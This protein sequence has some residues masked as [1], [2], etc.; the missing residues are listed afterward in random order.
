MSSIQFA[1]T[2]ELCVGFNAGVNAAKNLLSSNFEWCNGE[3]KE[4]A[5]RYQVIC[6]VCKKYID[7]DRLQRHMDERH[8]DFLRMTDD[9]MKRCIRKQDYVEKLQ[10]SEIDKLARFGY[11]YG[12]PADY[13]TQFTPTTEECVEKLNKQLK[14]GRKV[15]KSMLDGSATK[16]SL[17]NNWREALYMYWN[18]DFTL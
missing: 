7:N 6:C 8:G 17:P 15:F 5:G 16:Q 2:N 18:T 3:Q 1:S 11:E 13:M 9:E 10:Q 14:L 4:I 12:L